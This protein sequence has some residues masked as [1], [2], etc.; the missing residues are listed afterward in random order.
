[1][2]QISNFGSD[3][4]RN[5]SSKALLIAIALILRTT[6]RIRSRDIKDL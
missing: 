5:V 1:M 6:A 4:G 2:A 3:K